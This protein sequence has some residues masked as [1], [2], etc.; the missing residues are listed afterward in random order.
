MK[1]LNRWKIPCRPENRTPGGVHSR[2]RFRE[3]L[4]RE[5]LRTYR[6]G[7]VFSLLF[8]DVERSDTGPL[9]GRFVKYL[10][11][12]LR[13]TDEIGWNEDHRLSIM[14]PDTDESGSLALAGEI[15]RKMNHEVA[16]KKVMVH[17]RR[18]NFEI[19]LRPAVSHGIIQ[20]EIL[21][22]PKAE[23]LRR[24]RGGGSSPAGPAHGGRDGARRSSCWD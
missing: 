3:I 17:S 1:M 18:E 16:L 9:R 11:V 19:S 5:R 10:K 13:A 8:F 2:I 23:D 20:Y 12:R 15:T 22:P 4:E 6:S 14:L 24:A 7:S 21:K